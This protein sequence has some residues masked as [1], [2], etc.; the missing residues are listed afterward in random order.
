MVLHR[1]PA[2]MTVSFGQDILSVF[3]VWEDS[4]EFLGDII[5]SGIAP[6]REM[7][8]L[9][10]Q[11]LLA[12]AEAWH[13]LIECATS[14]QQSCRHDPRSLEGQD[15]ATYVCYALH[16]LPWHNEASQQDDWEDTDRLIVLAR[17]LERDASCLLSAASALASPEPP[18]GKSRRSLDAT[19]H[20]W[21]DA[22]LGPTFGGDA[23]AAYGLTAAARRLHLHNTSVRASR[24]YA[25]GNRRPAY[26]HPSSE[27]GECEAKEEKAAESSSVE[28]W[29][30]R[31]G[32]SPYFSAQPQTQSKVAAAA[33]R[34]P[35]GT[36]SCIRFPPLSCPR[37]G[38][39]Q[40]EVA[41]EPFWLLMA[42][43]F[44]IKTSGQVAIPAFRRVKQRFPTPL[45]L[46]DAA[47]EQELSDMIRH[48]GLVVARVSFIRRYAKAFLDCPPQAGIRYRVRNYD[49]RDVAPQSG[50]AGSGAEMAQRT[51]HRSE[52]SAGDGESWEI[53]HMTQGR[54]ALDSW[55]IFCRDELLGRADDWNG[56]GRE[57]EFQ[58]EWMRVL[59]ADKE[60][61]AYLR[62]M[63]MREGWEWDP[64]TG[65]RRVLGEEMRRA[66][67]EGR[68]EYDEAGGLRMVEE[69]PQS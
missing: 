20:F 65:E 30:P 7:Q 3:D 2:T 6:P 60:L 33:K 25:P 57:A 69:R 67:D 42:V 54:Y 51:V 28:L 29:P 24:W 64:A 48:L 10:D 45:Q 23:S 8:R 4:R 47:N 55:R 14:I 50:S 11:S 9:L 46:A 27:Q 31:S 43:T 56:K 59:P 62:W 35:A 44:L 41:G 66:V 13:A 37:F 63:W 61:R 17:K 21:A 1:L 68:V 15:A 16:G 40:E 5:Q 12:G 36:V 39:I 52:D 19:S 38:I 26:A 53:G 58:P 32:L 34:P 49:R 22:R 18:S